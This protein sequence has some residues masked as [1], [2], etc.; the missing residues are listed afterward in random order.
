MLNERQGEHGYS[1]ERQR[2]RL[3]A[4]RRFL[5]A[6]MDSDCGQ[7]SD[8]VALRLVRHSAARSSAAARPAALT[9]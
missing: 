9:G 1:T 8:R 7:G 3:R 4:C 2:A 5:A 6:V